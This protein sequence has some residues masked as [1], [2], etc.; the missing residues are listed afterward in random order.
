MQEYVGEIFRSLVSYISSLIP[1]EVGDAIQNKKTSATAPAYLVLGA[2]PGD[3]PY[4]R[5]FYENEQYWLLD[6]SRPIRHNADTSR[7]FLIDFTNPIQMSYLALQLANQ[8]D[9]IIFDY[10]TVKFFTASEGIINRLVDLKAMLKEGGAI[11]VEKVGPPGGARMIG[12]TTDYNAKFLEDCATAGLTL[13]VQKPYTEFADVPVVRDIY[14]TGE[15][16]AIIRR[17]TLTGTTDILE[18]KKAAGGGRRRQRKTL[19]KT[20][21]NRPKHFSFYPL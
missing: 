8:F 4:G 3:I 17:T 9:A 18:I 5:S 2:V 10:S 20:S 12:N 14:L 16:P 21:T 15:M 6:M 7:F 1:K 19:K 11:Y 13:S